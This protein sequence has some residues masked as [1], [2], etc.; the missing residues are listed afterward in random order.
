[1]IKIKGILLIATAL[2]SSFPTSVAA[3]DKKL[4]MVH[5]QMLPALLPDAGRPTTLEVLLPNNKD[6]S[7]KVTA[8]V[9]LDG[10][11]I[12]IPMEGGIGEKDR[13]IYKTVLKAPIKDLAYRFHAQASAESH[14]TTEQFRV[15]RMCEYQAS[16]VD[17]TIPKDKEVIE[18]ARSLSELS[19]ELE[20]ENES[21]SEVLTSLKRLQEE[22][23]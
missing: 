11:L 22:I 15:E 2:I 23:Q 3:E 8:E 20:K 13:T 7:V 5:R 6:L 17:V 1:M 19:R 16:N 12:N 9:I 21:Y 10:V 14:S 18:L 4:T